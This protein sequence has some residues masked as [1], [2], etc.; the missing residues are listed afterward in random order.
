MLIALGFLATTVTTILW[1]WGLSR[2]PA[3]QAGIFLNLEPVVGAMLGVTLLHEMLGMSA[4][5]GGLLIVAATLVV[6]F[7][8]AN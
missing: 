8:G 7:S 6:S 3:G 2:V 4:I 1:N 5:A